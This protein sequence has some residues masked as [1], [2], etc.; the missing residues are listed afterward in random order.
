MIVK[1]NPE[2]AV[3]VP[4]DCDFQKLRVCKYNVVGEITERKQLRQPFYDSTGDFSDEGY[5]EDYDEDGDDYGD[6]ESTDND[7]YESDATRLSIRNYIENKHEEDAEPTVKQIQS[8]MKG[9]TLTSQEIVD[10]VEE[11]GFEVEY[12]K[13]ALSRS[14]I[15]IGDEI[16]LTD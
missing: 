13:E 1:F 16:A 9:T 15:V 2:D 12:N 3:S 7:S 14:R 4:D 10:I 5:D 8:R 6:A 11:L